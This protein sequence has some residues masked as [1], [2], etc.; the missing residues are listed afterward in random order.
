VPK[1]TRSYP[2]YRL[3]N[4]ICIYLYNVVYFTDGHPGIKD[5]FEL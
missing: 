3:S 1:A 2:V 4:V 5:S